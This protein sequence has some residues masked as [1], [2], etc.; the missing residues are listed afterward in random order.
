MR[1]PISELYWR[2]SYLALFQV[3][4][5]NTVFIAFIRCESRSSVRCPSV[6]AY[7]F[8]KRYILLLSG[9]ILMKRPT[10]IPHMSGNCWKG[11]KVRGQRSRSYLY[12]CVNTTM[13][14]AYIS[15]VCYRGYYFFSF[16]LVN[17]RF[18]YVSTFM[19]TK[20]AHPAINLMKRLYF[21]FSNLSEYDA[22][23]LTSTSL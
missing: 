19:N 15:T 8:L 9:G 23:I 13:A 12:K 16:L 18:P 3:I 20:L 5:F 1:L 21:T 11:F 4:A 14:E 6:Y 10:N 22:F 2:I 7:L 17:W